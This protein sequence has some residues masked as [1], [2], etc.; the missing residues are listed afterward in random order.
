MGACTTPGPQGR[1]HLLQDVQDGTLCRQPSPQSAP[2]GGPSL[3][4]DL[5]KPG[6]LPAAFGLDSVITDEDRAEYKIVV[7]MPARDARDRPYKTVNQYVSDRT[8]FFGPPTEYARFAAES[9]AELDNTIWS[10]KRKYGTLKSRLEFEKKPKVQKVFYR[11]VRKAYLKKYGEDADVPELIRRGMS[12]ELAKQIKDVRG[13]VRLKKVHGE[14]FHAGGFNPRPKKLHGYRLGTLSEHGTGMAVDVDDSQNPQLTTD[15][16]AFIETLTGKN[17]GRKGR[18]TTEDDAEAF[19]NDI[20]TLSRLFVAKVA[21]E[22]KRIS[23]ERA[24]AAKKAAASAAKPA[25]AAKGKTP[26][27]PSPLE[28]VLGSHFKRLSKWT[29]TGF[30]QLPRELVLEMHGHGFTWGATFTDNVDLHHFELD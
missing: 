30:F 23:D 28:V 6:F 14:N 29:T 22:T 21:S 20:N 15:E 11:W 18:W 7:G 9:D 5:H 1:F 19:W 16:W 27:Q 12:D 2:T 8:F 3:W 4:P 25:G 26:A 10:R 13:S 17:V 24:A